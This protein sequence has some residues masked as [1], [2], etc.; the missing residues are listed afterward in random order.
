M[1]KQLTDNIVTEVAA[2]GPFW[3][4]EQC[5]KKRSAERSLVS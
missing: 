3:S 1:L 4:K 5:C 2:L